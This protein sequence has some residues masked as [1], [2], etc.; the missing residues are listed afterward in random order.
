MIE[1]E[2]VSEAKEFAT[3]TTQWSRYIRV[4]SER[5]SMESGDKG[6]LYNDG[7]VLLY[8]TAKQFDPSTRDFH[9]MFKT[10]LGHAFTDYVRSQKAQKRSVKKKSPLFYP[11]EDASSPNGGMHVDVL[12]QLVAGHK[13]NY[14]ATDFVRN[15]ISLLSPPEIE[16]LQ[17]LLDPSE[18]TWLLFESRQYRR[19]PKNI[20]L[21]V[22]ASSLGVTEK[23]VKILLRTIRLKYVKFSGKSELATCIPRV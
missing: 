8:E 23:R 14:E 15:F 10:K 3:L 9:K 17:E 4:M 19:I 21:V 13:D 18:Q 5:F 1:K 7:L 12:S 6:E 16:V 2:L 22:I 20:P 11:A